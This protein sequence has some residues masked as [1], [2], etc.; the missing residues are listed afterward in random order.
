MP[1]ADIVIQG[2][3]EHNLRSVDVVLPRNKLI[4]LTGVSGSGK[5]SLAFDTLYAEGQRRYVESLSTFA[6]QFLGQMPK[7]EVDHI[8]GLSP[9]I[10]ISQKSSGNNPRSTVGTITEIYDFLRVLYARVGRGHCPQCGKPIT[11][12]TREQIIGRILMLPAKTQFTV[13]APVIR[14]QK[15]EY[16]D[17]FEDFRKQGFVRARVDGNVVIALGR[18]LARPP[19]A[20]QHRSGR[21]PP[22]GG[23]EHP[24]PARGVGRHGARGGEGEPDSRRARG[25]LPRSAGD[26]PGRPRPREKT[27]R[28]EARTPRLTRTWKVP[29][30]FVAQRGRHPTRRHRPLGPLRLHRLRDQLRRADAAAIQ[31]QQSR[32]ACASNATGWA[33]SSASIRGGS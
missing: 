18:A 6:R 24:R 26:E 32:K 1:A 4:C 3:R 17:L 5:S 19:D 25:R 7:P 16:R 2:A 12:Q 21:R 28:T 27:L 22:H 31:L 23:A 29:P 33:S 9:S 20:A 8:S 14:G 30:I 10:S 13:L 15:G 11:A